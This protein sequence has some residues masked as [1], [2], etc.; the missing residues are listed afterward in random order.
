MKH[1]LV[2][3]LTMIAMGSA[4]AQAYVGGSLGMA[5]VNLDC[6]GTLSCDTTD[7]SWK[8]YAGYKLDDTWAVEGG[9]IDFGRA[10]YSYDFDGDTINGKLSATG[11]T[12][13]VAA[14]GQ[15]TPAVSGVAR[16]GLAMLKAK[17]SESLGSAS[18]SE[19][20]SNTRAYLGLGLGYA[21]TPNLTATVDADFSTAKLGGES[22]SVR[23]IGLG[24][25]YKF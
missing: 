1:I 15:F 21:V 19:S 11:F 24:L 12:V 5:K 14:H 18:V 3:G 23:A 25:A 9:Y 16:F 6:A 10:K 13:A 7:T 4:S 22:G 17:I 20:E 2:A 8:L